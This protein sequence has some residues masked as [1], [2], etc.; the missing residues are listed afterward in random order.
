MGDLNSKTGMDTTEYVDIMERHRVGEKNENDD[1]FSNLCVFNKSVIGGTIFLHER[2]H[3]DNW[4]STDHTTLNHIDHIHINKISRMSMED[5]RN[6]READIASDNQQLVVVDMK[7]ILNKH[8]ITKETA[9]QRFNTVSHSYTDKLIEFKITLNNRF[10]VI[11][12][13]LKE[14]RKAI[15]EDNWKEITEALTSMCQ[16]V[17]GCTKHRHKE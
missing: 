14:E 16:E 7:L 10:Q 9:L 4:V 15:M 3:K 17:L 13:L 2:I 12:D 6:R 1:G 5:V 11:Q 8:W